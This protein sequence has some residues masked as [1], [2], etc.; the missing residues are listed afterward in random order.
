M[1]EY[2][3]EKVAVVVR[4]TFEVFDRLAAKSLVST[5][6][7]N[8]THAESPTELT[9]SSSQCCSPF[10]TPSIPTAHRNQKTKSSPFS[11]PSPYIPKCL[12][13]AHRVRRQSQ[14]VPQVP[15][16]QT[17]FA[18]TLLE[19]SLLISRVYRPV[20]LLTNPPRRMILG[21][22]E[23]PFLHRRRLLNVKA[24]S[25]KSYLRSKRQR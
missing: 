3:Q 22:I 13:P 25:P 4:T 9:P 1:S 12:C 6:D 19:A 15:Y 10:P 5:R 11:N 21:R 16:G 14:L 7:L 20:Y 8:V 23:H 24:G 18:R 2:V 17:R